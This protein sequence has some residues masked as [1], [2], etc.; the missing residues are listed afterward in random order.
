MK[1]KELVLGVMVLMLASGVCSARSHDDDDDFHDH[2]RDSSADSG[3]GLVVAGGVEEGGDQLGPIL[4]ADGSSLY[5]HLGDGV[6]FNVGGHYK[7]ASPHLDVMATIGYKYGTTRTKITNAN[8]YVSRVVAQLLAS[9]SF[10]DSWWAGAGPVWHLNNSYRA[11]KNVTGLSNID[12]DKSLGV[13]VQGGWRFI[14][15]TYTNMKYADKITKV[16]YGANSLGL[17][18]IGRF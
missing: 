5:M 7:F 1:V 14:A 11:D 8:V 13:T 15:F 10:T 16:K 9:Y 12:F 6:N 18:L 17:E 2:S 3:L 4:L